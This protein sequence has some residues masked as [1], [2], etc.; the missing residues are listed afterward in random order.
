M[1]NYIFGAAEFH[2]GF[3]KIFFLNV[4]VSF[5]SVVTWITIDGEIWMFCT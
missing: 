4:L 5:N 2:S 1:V 3:F